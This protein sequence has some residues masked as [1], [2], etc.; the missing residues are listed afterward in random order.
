[1]NP[2]VDIPL[3]AAIPAA[4]FLVIGATLALIGSFGLARIPTFLERLHAPTLG[5]SWGVAGIAICSMI[6]STVVTGRPIIHELLIAVFIMITTPVTLMLLGRA[7]LYRQQAEK[8]E[9]EQKRAA[10]ERAERA[11]DPDRAED[12]G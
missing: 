9:A 11:L 5:T 8:A 10:L 6:V 3:W 1:M 7:V 12:A 4:F 2:A